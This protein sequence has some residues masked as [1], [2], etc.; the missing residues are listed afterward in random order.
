MRVL[1]GN[2]KVRAQIYTREET[3]TA[4][5][6]DSEVPV[7]I[8]TG[9]S[10]GIGRATA[11]ALGKAGCK[12]GDLSLVR[13]SL[14]YLSIVFVRDGNY[15]LVLVAVDVGMVFRYWLTMLVHRRRPRKLL[16][17]LVTLSTVK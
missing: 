16:E 4:K 1:L 10:R 8:V 14:V 5:T 3:I 2:G 15:V 6:R 17:R 12:V 9:A 11:L 13:V 7:V